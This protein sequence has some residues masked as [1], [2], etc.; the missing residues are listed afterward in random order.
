MTNF[1]RLKQMTVEEMADFINDIT[2]CCRYDEC[3]SCHLYKFY[4]N[5]CDKKR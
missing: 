5:S 3:Q 4:N 2:F 1:E